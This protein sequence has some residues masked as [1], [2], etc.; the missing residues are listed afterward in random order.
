MDVEK[1]EPSRAG[2]NMN[3]AAILEN[4]LAVPQ[5]VKDL[6]FDLGNSLLGIYPKEMKTWPHKNLYTNIHSSIIH[7]SQKVKTTQMPI[8]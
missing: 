5:K 6:S 1:S 7:S 8:N 2:E 4:S 3:C